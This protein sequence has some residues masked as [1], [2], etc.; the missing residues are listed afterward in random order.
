[1]TDEIKKE[2]SS[3]R[4]FRVTDD[5][6]ARFNAV[7]DDLKLN[8]DAALAML[9][10]AYELERAKEVLPDRETEIANF[11]M[12]ARELVDAFIFSLQL[13]ADAEDRVR[14]EVVLKIETLERVIVDYQQKLEQAKQKIGVLEA[15]K[16]QL[17]AS[18]TELDQLRLEMSKAMQDQ[19]AMKISYEKQM[20]D[21]EEINA[22]LQEKL[23]EAEKK[24][25]GYDPLKAE[26]DALAADLSAAKD[27]LTEQ[28]RDSEIQAERAARA[29]EK[30]KEA[31]VAYVKDEA[32]EK[33][34]VLR[35]KLQ[36]A[37]IDAVRQLRA[38]DKESTAEIRKL[39]QE[40]ARLREL[41]ASLQA[42]GEQQ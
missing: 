22:M 37:Q 20:K 39:E 11:Q 17:E 23:A 15:D 28:Q 21:K 14:G 42:K 16:A 2:Q 31:A 26:R 30:A 25:A 12:K 35:E 32:E 18:I 4:S 41:V 8:Q 36:Q 3:V 5:V 13:N 1:M 27:A 29:A 7:K 34:T 10:N 33:V 40:N 38:A 9:I 19:E 6:M 24:A